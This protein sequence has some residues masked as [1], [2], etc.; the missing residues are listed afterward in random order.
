[1]N[2][3][4][5]PQPGRS[6]LL[7]TLVT[8]G[9]HEFRFLVT[10]AVLAAGVWIF[11]ELADEVTEGE[12]R[13]IDKV[14]LLSLRSSHDPTDPLGPRWVEELG[15]DLTA[16]GGVG[17][18][19]LVTLAV[20]GFLLLQRKTGAA[21]LVIAAAT[22]AVIVSTVLKRYY[23]R[24]RPDL[25]PHGS[26]VYTSSFPSGHS[27]LSAAVY[28]TLAA[29]LARIQA[30]NRVKAYLLL[31][32]TLITL[33]V[34]LSRVYLGVHWPTDVL[35]GWT[36]GGVWALACWTIAN[37]LQRRGAV[38]KPGEEPSQK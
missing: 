33:V 20:C 4:D 11:A 37:W 12:T 26:F 34:G 13:E 18:L 30:R 5:Q 25:V 35:S 2:S 32:A 22:G 6:G 31:M 38:E 16:L 24:P 36:A 19:T 1:M 7:R 14:I 9:R 27:M 17:V 29:L 28:L 15:R 8:L 3:P 10:L 21:A 23:D